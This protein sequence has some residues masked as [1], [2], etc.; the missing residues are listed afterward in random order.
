[1]KRSGSFQAALFVAVL[2]PVLTSSALAGGSGYR[3]W[4]NTEP[5]TPQHYS[6]NGDPSIYA[7]GDVIYV[8]EKEFD[9][10]GLF[11]TLG[12]ERDC[13]FV[14]TSGR[15]DAAEGR[16]PSAER[17]PRDS[18]VFLELPDGRRKIVGLEVSWTI[19]H[20]DEQTPDKTQGAKK[21]P[22]FDRISYNPMDSMSP[23]EI[24]G[25][26]GI[27]LVQWPK[28][29]EQELAYVDTNR[30]CLT[31]HEGAGPGGQPG[32]LWG[33]P[34]F[35]PIPLKTRYLVVQKTSSPGLRDFSPLGRSRDLVFLKFRSI[36]SEPLD[37]AWIS[38]NASLRYLDLLRLWRLKLP[39]AGR[40]DRAAL[41]EHQR[42]QR[43][44][45]HRV[46]QRHAP[47]QDTPGGADQGNESI[48]AGRL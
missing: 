1:M 37:A 23:E 4:I 34:V 36:A 39:E 44:R 6:L 30:V 40:S 26:W 28:G 42:V 19:T 46:R 18:R 47:A 14:T 48:A 38:P 25:L 8:G 43:L 13:R 20:P 27:S 41:S 5:V 24:H 15:I 12:D 10:G 33:G 22:S 21:Q 32:S 2:T 9:Y 3:F 35:P 31:V 16:G 45:G 17:S 11:M 29:I 7:P